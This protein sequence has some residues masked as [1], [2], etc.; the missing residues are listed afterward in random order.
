MFA[1]C[2]VLDFGRRAYVSVIG[3]SILIGVSWLWGGLATYSYGLAD[4]T[5]RTYDY[6]ESGVIQAFALMFVWGYCDA[7]VQTWCYWVMKQLFTSSEDFARIAGIFKFAQSFGSAASFLIDYA[8]PTTIVQLW[9]NVI[10]FVISLPGAFYL[11]MHV[12][13]AQD[14]GLVSNAQKVVD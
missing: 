13:R 2:K 1:G 12:S 11:C 3:S 7:L 8:H 4:D 14:N 10:L 9:I 5:A 6:N